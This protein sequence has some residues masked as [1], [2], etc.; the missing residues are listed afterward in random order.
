MVP[1]SFKMKL[2]VFQVDCVLGQRYGVTQRAGAGAGHEVKR[3]N[4]AFD[5]FLEQVHALV[6]AKRVCLAG[7]AEGGERGAA[8]IPQQPFGML[9]EAIGIWSAILTEGGQDG[10]DNAREI[11]RLG[12]VTSLRG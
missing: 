4:P 2:Q 7:R 1:A 11:R 3:L 8:S 5:E 9:D 6:Y 12:H 10:R